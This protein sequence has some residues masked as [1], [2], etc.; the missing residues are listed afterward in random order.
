MCLSLISMAMYGS[1]QPGQRARLSVGLQQAGWI[2]AACGASRT[3]RTS[4]LSSPNSFLEPE[5]VK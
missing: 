4:V 1:L 3:R 2:Q 5:K